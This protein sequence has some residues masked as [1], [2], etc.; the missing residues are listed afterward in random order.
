MRP[1]RLA[2]LACLMLLL[3]GC[4]Y[5]N[6]VYNAKRLTREAEQAE[7][8]GRRFEAQGLYA[9]AVVKADSV[10]ARYPRSSWADDARFL[11][12][13]A[14]ARTRSCEQGVTDLELVAATS[15]DSALAA[16]AEEVLA[17]C[18]LE[19][20]RPDDAVV[21]Y[22]RRWAASDSVDRVRL[23]PAYVRALQ[24][25]GRASEA[26]AILALDGARI[27]LEHQL[28]VAASRGE[29]ARALEL[30]EALLADTT[31]VDWP[32]LVRG[33]ARE[34]PAFASTMTQRLAASEAVPPAIRFQ[35]RVDEAER[36]IARDTAR[37]REQY[38]LALA[39]ATDVRGTAPARAGLTSLALA[40]ADTADLTRLADSLDAV[41]AL[42]GATAVV[43]ARRAESFQ[44]LRAVRDSL[45]SLDSLPQGDM[46]H[47]LLA[48][49]VRDSIGAPRAAASY[50][51]AMTAAHP[52]SPY[53][54]KALLAAALL[55][56]E[57]RDSL[58]AIAFSRYP[59]SPYVLLLQG[60]DTPGYRALED[61]LRL[62]TAAEFR[63]RAEQRG[64][65][66][67]QVDIQD[68]LP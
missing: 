28:A 1:A 15:P 25:A 19:L 53:A 29:D 51:Q 40:E 35:L 3:S 50:F 38:Q 23:A 2:Q 54:A 36:W 67:N 66:R 45:A 43:A 31:A 60:H 47:F 64:P 41:V 27:P 42:G 12:G 39:S 5:Y 61:S 46:W 37:A 34:N 17:G 9:Q 22:E 56:P 33:V 21:R 18:Y 14:L 65:R 58:V 11:R 32:E 55:R 4:V 57:L 68:D 63:R 26:A 44:R 20:D 24:E 62:W 6:G 52:A 8:E 10:L 49:L 30:L 16:R 59:A 13:N 7:R 48:E